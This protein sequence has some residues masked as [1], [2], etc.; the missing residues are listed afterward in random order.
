V[1]ACLSEARALTQAPQFGEGCNEASLAADHIGLATIAADLR[2]MVA[3]ADPDER[4]ILINRL[5]E[6][7]DKL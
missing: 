1:Q 3:T 6:A 4:L 5:Q 7:I 2:S